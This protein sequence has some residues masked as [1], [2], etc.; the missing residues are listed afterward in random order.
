MNGTMRPAK[1]DEVI[2]RGKALPEGLRIAYVAC[3]TPT[4]RRY[5]FEDGTV[6]LRLADVER[7]IAAVEATA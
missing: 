3:P 4:T 2:A 1:E 7:V 6:L 5:V